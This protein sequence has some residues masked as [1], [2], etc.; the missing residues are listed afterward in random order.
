MSA[1][2]AWSGRRVLVTGATGIVGSWLVGALLERGAT[3]VAL[4]VDRDP[5][6]EIVRS[7]DF[8][9]IKVVFGALEDYGAVDR[10]VGVWEVDTVVHLAAQ[11]LVGPARR[12]PLPTFETNIRGTYNLLEVCRLHADVVK[13]VVVASSDK[14]YGTADLPFSPEAVADYL[15]KFS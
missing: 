2:S 5:Q 12:S 15:N 14:V 1:A 13:A 10:A 9:R 4:V 11:T 8:D 6:S 3:V 7:G